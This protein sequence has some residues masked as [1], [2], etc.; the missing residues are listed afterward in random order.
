[1]RGRL[2]FFQS[3]FFR[4][5]TDLLIKKGHNGNT[6]ENVKR[7]HFL[8]YAFYSGMLF[9]IG[10]LLFSNIPAGNVT[11]IASDISI[12]ASIGLIVYVARYRGQ[13]TAAFIITISMLVFVL[14]INYFAETAER[15]VYLMP[16]CLLFAYFLL[17]KIGGVAWTSILYGV[18]IGVFLIHTYTPY[19]MALDPINLFYGSIALFFISAMLY[20]FE[21]NNE[22][23]EKVIQEQRKK[24]MKANEAL[25][26][27]LLSRM[28]LTTQLEKQVKEV[29]RS[30]S[31]LQ[32]SKK[33]LINVLEDTNELQQQ[34]TREKSNIEKKIDQRTKELRQEQA[35][36]HASIERL[37]L[38]FLLT[39]DKDSAVIHNPALFSVLGWDP[40]EVD[41]RLLLSVFC[42]QLLPSYNL[43]VDID[44][45]RQSGEPFSVGDIKF[46][47]KYIRIMGSAI[48]LD[49]TDESIGIVLLVEDMSEV[50][51]LERSKDEFVSIASHELR[52]PL[53]AIRGNLSMIQLMHP[54][55]FKENDVK[56]M[57]DD[58]INSVVRLTNIVNDFLT[59]SRLEQ[60]KTLFDLE[61][62]NLYD[63]SAAV[64]K[65][66]G[67]MAEEK[68]IV[69]RL[70][71]PKNVAKVRADKS[72][73]QGVLNNL[74]GNAIKYSSTGDIIIASK[75]GRGFL[76][77]SIKDNGVGIDRKNRE[78]LFHKFQQATDNIYTRDDSRSTGLGLYI[79]KMM[80]DQMGGRI[81]LEESAPGEGSTFCFKLPIA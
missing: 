76:Y 61:A 79:A 48:K 66:L 37:N 27:D 65:E 52:T 35:R 19:K 42:D 38:G 11:A 33:A 26:A 63:L 16:A 60:K 39:I 45:C 68:G 80:V 23:N 17:G 12:L 46:K 25:R 40:A 44:T 67:A 30:N 64:V 72:K 14:P 54:D 21:Y 77:V 58:A 62:V 3:H 9:V 47:D 78:L 73:V 74:V 70:K 18:N 4:T 50:K 75:V 24:L 57:M 49:D 20:V 69:L 43:K 7:L 5:A 36:L 15:S 56:E 1:M 28:E 81:W 2:S 8:A 22:T 59:T 31:I 13:Y 71:I 29:E 41:D 53:T 32:K 55:I 6:P 34:L 10:L 51:R